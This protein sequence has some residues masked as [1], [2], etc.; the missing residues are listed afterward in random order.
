[1]AEATFTARDCERSGDD[2]ALSERPWC[3]L[4]G[5]GVVEGVDSAGDGDLTRRF[6]IVPSRGAP[7][8]LI[9]LDS[10]AYTSAAASLC[11][12][13]RRLGRVVAWGLR[14]G[15]AL[16]VLGWVSSRL[17]VRIPRQPALEARIAEMVGQDVRLAIQARRVGDVRSTVTFAAVTERPSVE[18]IARVVVAPSGEA[19]LSREGAALRQLKALGVPHGELRWIGDVGGH[20]TLLRDAVNGR[21]SSSGWTAAHEAFVEAMRYGS[22]RSI[23]DSE[24][25]ADLQQKVAAHSEVQEFTSPLAEAIVILRPIEARPV[26][27]HRDPAPWN[28]LV[29]DTGEITFIDWESAEIDGIPYLD[30]F[31]FDLAIGINLLGWTRQAVSEYGRTWGTSAD[32]GLSEQ[33][34]HALAVVLLLDRITWRFENDQVSLQGD[35]LIEGCI[36][37]LRRLIVA[38]SSIRDDGAESQPLPGG[39]YSSAFQGETDALEYDAR[40]YGD[41]TYD[42]FVWGLQRPRLRR[43]FRDA[44]GSSD[45]F[46]HLDFACG[47]GRILASVEDLAT[48]STGIDISEEMLAAARSKVARAILRSGDIVAEPEI[49]GGP[50]DVITAFRFFLNAEPGLR[51]DVMAALAGRLRDQNSR[52]IFNVHGSRRSVRRFAVRGR[53]GPFM[54]EMSPYEIRLMVERAGL[55]VVSVF[56]LGVTP[57]RLHRTPLARLMRAVDR[58][59]ARVPLARSV[60]VDLI[61]V[62]RA[63]RARSG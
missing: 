24:L 16:G 1:M 37:G 8:W 46:T 21:L 20:T 36:D 13:T 3:L 6:A 39:D 30:R 53:R 27:N 50:F 35:V 38:D 62:V 26:I 18:M 11:R 9:P 2:V 63:A 43:L 49:M 17:S 47:T 45:E 58:L 28:V 31:S 44:R 59:A 56:G 54:N 41:G 7:R 34:A 14:V 60:S 40:V 48:A 61:Y 33:Q 22:A 52:I 4:V 23:A 32:L 15:A 10:R 57:A 42:T 12:P 55:E 5:E 51:D 19:I 25:I 29:R